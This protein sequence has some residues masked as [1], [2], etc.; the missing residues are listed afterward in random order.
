MTKR[1]LIS[2][3]LCTVLKLNLIQVFINFVHQNMQ[4]CAGM[5]TLLPDNG[6]NQ[7]LVK[8]YPIFM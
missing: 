6:T 2:I 7:L 8:F 5:G 1:K 4:I 3:F